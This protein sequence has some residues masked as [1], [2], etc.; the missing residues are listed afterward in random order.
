MPGRLRS[1]AFAAGRA[2][3][4]T[5]AALPTPRHRP[6]WPIIATAVTAVVAVLAGAAVLARPWPHTRPTPG[7][8][9]Q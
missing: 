8:A 6:R 5:T 2:A 4:T 1:R 9:P 7:A 3:I